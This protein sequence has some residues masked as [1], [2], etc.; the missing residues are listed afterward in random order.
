MIISLPSGPW[1]ILGDLPIPQIC[2]HTTIQLPTPPLVPTEEPEPCIAPLDQLEEFS[3][4]AAH[5]ERKI[6]LVASLL[7]QLQRQILE[8]VSEF[9]HVFAWSPT[10][11]D[12][13][14]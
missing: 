6:R 3:I 4:D 9:S 13:I 10:D 14:P 8:V 1:I 7:S 12:V 2:Y 11:L 5:P